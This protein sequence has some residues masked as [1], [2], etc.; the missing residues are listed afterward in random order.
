[1]N[2]GLNQTINQTLQLQKLTKK[3]TQ[4]YHC[5][6]NDKQEAKRMLS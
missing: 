1:V 6:I 3:A 5:A 2:Q 4:Q